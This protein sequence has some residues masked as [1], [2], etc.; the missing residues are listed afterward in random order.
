MLADIW[1]ILVGIFA[2][3]G[4]GFSVGQGAAILF[5]RIG[6]DHQGANS[7]FGFFTVS[8][9]GLVAGFLLVTRAMLRWRSDLASIGNGLK[10]GGITALA[11]GTMV[12]LFAV[13]NRPG[14]GLPVR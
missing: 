12:V 4:L 8:P 13:A 7:T 10:I 2:A 5:T 1:A 6:G 3:L 14:V 9:F 11:L